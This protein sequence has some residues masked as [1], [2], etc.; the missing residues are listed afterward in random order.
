[1]AEE[2]TREGGGRVTIATKWEEV[3]MIVKFTPTSRWI[4]TVQILREGM[5]I[6]K[7]YCSR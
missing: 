2:D 6:S 1:M 5:R 4:C 7:E 3:L